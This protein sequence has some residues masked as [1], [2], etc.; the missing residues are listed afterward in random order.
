MKYI[1]KEVITYKIFQLVSLNRED[2]SFE[3]RLKEVDLKVRGNQFSSKQTA[4]NYILKNREKFYFMDLLISP[5]ISIGGE[6]EKKEDNEN[7]D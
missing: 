3:S 5:F 4:V 6:I 7:K 1:K 2:G